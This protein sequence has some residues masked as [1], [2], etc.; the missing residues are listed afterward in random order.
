MNFAT[1]T[2]V[3]FIFIVFVLYKITKDHKH[4]KYILVTASIF[5]YGYW[6]PPALLIILGSGLLDYFCSLRLVRGEKRWLILSITGNLGTLFVFKYFNFF[7]T[8]IVTYFS[9]MGFDPPSVYLDII[10]PMGISFY[11][12]QSMSYTIDVYRKQLSPCKSFLDF[13]LYKLSF[14]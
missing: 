3:S 8:Y 12:F 13:F 11:T 5:F 6:Y 4:H 2:F 7:T 9:W 14:S 10:L 1:F